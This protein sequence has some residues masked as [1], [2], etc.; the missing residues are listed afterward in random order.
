[1]SDRLRPTDPQPAPAVTESGL[2][3][4]DVVADEVRGLGPIGALVAADVAERRAHGL[5]K[6]GTVLRPFNG[7]DAFVDLYQELL[8]ASQYARQ[9]IAEALLA[10][11]DGPVAGLYGQLLMMCVQ[12][13]AQLVDQETDGA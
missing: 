11:A 12:V 5:A 2:V 6:Y 9:I 1:M 10:G 7:R 4:Q 8:D 13:R 3:I